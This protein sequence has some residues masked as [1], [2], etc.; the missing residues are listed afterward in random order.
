[1]WLGK[2]SCQILCAI[3][4]MTLNARQK[5]NHRNTNSMTSCLHGARFPPHD[6]QHG[7]TVTHHCYTWYISQ[8]KIATLNIAVPTPQPNHK[9]MPFSNVPFLITL[10]HETLAF[11]CEMIYRQKVCCRS[12]IGLLFVWGWPSLT[13]KIVH[14]AKPLDPSMLYPS[15]FYPS[16][17]S[18]SRMLTKALQWW[19]QSLR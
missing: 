16:S 14:I 3:C 19:P 15:S 6:G 13:K 12:F 9:N 1:M 10:M 4:M 7:N 2:L 8:R 18:F 5:V 17:F 11:A